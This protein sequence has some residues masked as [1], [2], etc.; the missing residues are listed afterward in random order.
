MAECSICLNQQSAQLCNEYLLEGKLTLAAIAE[1]IGSSKSAVGRHSLR[2]F[3]EWKAERLRT[4]KGKPTDTGR[5]LVAWPSGECTFFGEPIA[6]TDIRSDDEFLVVTYA[7]PFM[8][9]QH[10]LAL[11]EDAERTESLKLAPAAE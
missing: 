7:L 3:R 11:R 4:K 9:H 10:A 1:K 6:P 8:E 2:C 5:L